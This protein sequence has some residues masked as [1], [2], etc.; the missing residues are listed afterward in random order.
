MK[1]KH[2]FPLLAALVCAAGLL[3]MRGGDRPALLDDPALPGGGAS[4]PEVAIGDQ[5]VPLA[6]APENPEIEI[7]EELPPL[8]RLPQTG[9]LWWPVPLMALAGAV[10]I[11]FGAGDRRRNSGNA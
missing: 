9:L 6:E 1:K 10:F 5:E 7:N 2:L 8:A 3:W 11:V 4:V